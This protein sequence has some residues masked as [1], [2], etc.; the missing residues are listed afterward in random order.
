[1]V[2]QRAIWPAPD[3][4]DSE[5]RMTVEVALREEVLLATPRVTRLRYE[6]AHAEGTMR[7]RDDAPTPWDGPPETVGRTF[8]LMLTDRGPLIVPYERERLAPR[9]ASW[10]EVIAENV[11]CCWPVPPT[12][13][14]AGMEWQAMPAIPGGLP[15]GVVSADFEMRH[16]AVDVFDGAADIEIQFS[17]KVALETKTAAQARRGEG[18]GEVAVRLD[19]RCGLMTASRHSRMELIRPTTKN[20]ILRSE[21][22]V[23]AE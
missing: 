8:E 12:D 23:S 2:E 17:V 16:R 1:M 7:L 9:I 19:R 21:L 13:L 20:Q 22:A 3:G 18:H 5:L 14:K 10:L 6:I 15:P 4:S 11:R